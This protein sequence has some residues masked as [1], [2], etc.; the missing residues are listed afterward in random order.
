[1]SWDNE[2]R[3]RAIEMHAQGVSLTDCAGTLKV[4]Y[5]TVHSWVVRAGQRAERKRKKF[6]RPAGRDYADLKARAI[7]LRMAGIGYSRIADHL[8]LGD[9]RVMGWLTEAKR[10]GHKFPEAKR[11]APLPREVGPAEAPQKMS[12]RPPAD[13]TIA[14]KPPAPPAP[15]TALA[16]VDGQTLYER[17]RMAREALT[18]AGVPTVAA[19][20][21]GGAHALEAKVARLEGKIEALMIERDAL[22]KI[23]DRL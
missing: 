23:V 12:E 14:A 11:G 13:V 15:E 7:A 22:R 5:K 4:P 6:E 1:M 3:H 2:T 18:A 19:P 21:A 20:S 8:K 16:P 17:L 10:A 9:K